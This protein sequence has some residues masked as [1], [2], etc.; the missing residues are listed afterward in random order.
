MAQ[1]RPERENA[2][3]LQSEPAADR[4]LSDS[5][6]SGLRIDVSMAA[7]PIVAIVLGAI[8]AY[9]FASQQAPRF[10]AQSDV[11]FE[12]RELDWAVAERFLATQKVIV[13]SHATLDAVAEKTE[14]SI[15]QLEHDLTVEVIE[16]SGVMRFQYVD[17]SSPTALTVLKMVIERYLLLVRQFEQAEGGS[18]LLLTPPFAIEGPVSPRPLRA[19]ALGALAGFLLG[20]L[21]VMVK[22]QLWPKN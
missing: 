14:A 18:H 9:L 5:A 4:S 22:T 11:V 21:L 12:L 16:S 13:K 15:D 8:A 6:G 7:L 20:A 17:E 2:Y 1:V 19:A 3:R 10:A